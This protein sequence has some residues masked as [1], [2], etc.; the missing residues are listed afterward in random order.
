MGCLFILYVD[1]PATRDFGFDAF[2]DS[3]VP[4]CKT[5]VL[6]V[7]AALENQ[8]TINDSSCD[9]ATQHRRC[10]YLVNVVLLVDHHD[11]VGR[12]IWIASATMCLILNPCI[13]NY[14]IARQDLGT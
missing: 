7:W 6:S 12:R 14:S 2:H 9:F 4:R 10:V 13:S 11:D 1:A 8:R 3:L 5:A